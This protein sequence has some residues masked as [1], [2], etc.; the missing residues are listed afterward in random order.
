MKKT[1]VSALFAAF[2]ALCVIGAEAQELAP[3]KEG[4]DVYVYDSRGR[5]DPFMSIIV[6]VAETPPG[7]IKTPIESFDIEQVKLTAVVWTDGEHYALIKLPDGKHYVIREGMN[8]GIHK[9]Q[10]AKIV[11]DAVLIKEMV[12]DYR[13]QL[14]SKDSII[15]L[16]KEEA[17]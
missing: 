14:K 1:L 11:A 8:I 15:K 9:G 3:P 13:G 5:R 4:S 17:E 6:A 16:R 12:K 7:E 2:S 10:V